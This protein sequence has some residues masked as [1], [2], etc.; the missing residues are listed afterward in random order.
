MEEIKVVVTE[1]FKFR[2]RDASV[3]IAFLEV[4]DNQITN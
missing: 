3:K 1:K 4:V 2:Y